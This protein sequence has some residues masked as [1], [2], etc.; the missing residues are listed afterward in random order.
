MVGLK[1]GS[2]VIFLLK[3]PVISIL[4]EWGQ[5]HLQGW[6]P[7][8]NPPPTAVVQVRGDAPETINKGNHE[9]GDS[10]MFYAMKLDMG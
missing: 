1:E 3:A 10:R 5:G 4:W 9:K 6:R 7:R 8:R 2:P